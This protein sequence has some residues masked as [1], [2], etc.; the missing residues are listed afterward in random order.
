ML[1]MKRAREVFEA[2]EDFTVGIE[3]EFGILDPETRSLTQRFEELK[4]ASEADDLLRDRV[5]GE[6]ISS[7]IEIRSEKGATFAHAVASQRDARARLFRLAADPPALRDPRAVRQLRGLRG[8]R[9]AARPDALDRRAHATVVER[10][11]PPLLRDR[12][13]AHLRRADRRRGIDC[14]RRSPGRVRR[15]GGNRLRRGARA[16]AAAAAAARREPLARDPPRPR[17]AH[18]RSR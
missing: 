6:L 11:A 1:D 13:A 15:A 2:S 16:A 9:R 3:E 12:G 4:E 17:R 7:E 18:D 10:Q 8:A 5:A 14:P